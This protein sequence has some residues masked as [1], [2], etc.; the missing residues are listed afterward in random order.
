MIKHLLSVVALLMF[1]TYSYGQTRLDKSFAFQTNPA[2]KYSIYVPTSYNSSAANKMM[3]GFH[4]FNTARWDA[5]AWCDTLVAFAESNNLILVCPDGDADGRV[6]DAIDFA[7]TTALI[8][9]MKKWYNINNSKIFA[10]GFSVGG[11]ATYEY[12]L[13]NSS[14]FAGYIPIGAA[15]NASTFSTNAANAKDKPY[16]LVHGANDAVAARFTPAKNALATNGACEKDTLMSGVGHTI[17]F[18]NR[19]AILT[20]AF[21]WIDTVKCGTVG[22]KKL[23]HKLND[24]VVYPTT[25]V[26]GGKI[27]VKIN[28][29][30]PTIKIYNVQGQ[31]I[32][33]RTEVARTST[34]T[35]IDVVPSTMASGIYYLHITNH[36]NEQGVYKFIV[37]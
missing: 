12:G 26:N 27:T 22:L 23:T 6:D 19:N 34:Q 35:I 2:K 1:C 15:I 14:M 37:Q 36:K 18:P 31:Q 10:M 7:F 24:I 13:A 17:D 30:K 28:G 3:V 20:I 5:K 4:P 11:K 9:S 16:F 8:D 25:I 21:K 33:H 32:Q 29:D